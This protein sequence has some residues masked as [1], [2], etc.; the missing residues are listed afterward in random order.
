MINNQYDEYDIFAYDP[1]FDENNIGDTSNTDITLETLDVD[2]VILNPDN[3]RYNKRDKSE[4]L[5]EFAENIRAQGLQNPIV[6]KRLGPEGTNDYNQY[7][8]L[9]GER[10]YR[11]ITEYLGWKTAEFRVYPY[12]ISKGLEAIILDGSNLCQRVCSTEELFNGYLN[13]T[14]NTKDS[15]EYAKLHNLSRNKVKM[16]ERIIKNTSEEDLKK[17]QEGEI[18][19]NDIKSLVDAQLAVKAQQQRVNEYK[20]TY[21]KNQNNVGSKMYIDYDLT[22]IFYVDCKNSKKS[23]Y[24][25]KEHN[26][27]SKMP[28]IWIRSEELPLSNSREEMQLFLDVFAEV[29]HYEELTDEEYLTLMNKREKL[30]DGKDKDKPDKKENRFQKNSFPNIVISPDSIDSDTSEDVS[31]SEEERQNLAAEYQNG[32]DYTN[33]SDEL[34]DEQTSASSDINKT[35]SSRKEKHNITVK[36]PDSIQ[37][38]LLK[39]KYALSV[40]FVGIDIENGQQR[41]GRLLMNDE[42]RCFIVES[43]ND[44]RILDAEH[45]NPL[46]LSVEVFEV[47]PESV[48]IQSD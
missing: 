17:Y 11:A 20:S 26:Y 46:I 6:V 40:S 5:E 9:S 29:N 2:R 12:D 18:S 34:K 35:Q 45:E 43:K 23:I 24:G 19:F 10:R 21:A 4:D 13:L 44:I 37:M 48:L 30:Y 7:M 39:N 16:F 8:V 36:K 25:V 31:I 33:D 28:P 22:R 47:E 42:N 3:T 41:I 14:K 38:D 27:D 15:A 1:I 32:S